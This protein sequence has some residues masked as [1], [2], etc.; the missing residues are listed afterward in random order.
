MKLAQYLDYAVTVDKYSAWKYE[1]FS[2]CKPIVTQWGTFEKQN[3]DPDLI[4]QNSPM[5]Y[6]SSE[7]KTPSENGSFLISQSLA[8]IILNVLGQDGRMEEFPIRR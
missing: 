4:G 5:I 2:Y 3:F 7:A 6:H 8:D 1:G